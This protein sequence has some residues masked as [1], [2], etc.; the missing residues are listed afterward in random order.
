MAR[1]A[2]PVVGRNLRIV[3]SELGTGGVAARSRRAGIRPGTRRPEPAPACER[4]RPSRRDA[5]SLEPVERRRGSWNAGQYH[6]PLSPRRVRPASRLCPVAHG[7]DVHGAGSDVQPSS[8]ANIPA[9]SK[10]IGCSGSTTS[11]PPARSSGRQRR[12]HVEQLEMLGVADPHDARRL[13]RDVQAA[14]D[15]HRQG[16]A[17]GVDRER[18]ACA[19]GSLGRDA[20][21]VRL[22][23]VDSLDARAQGDVGHADADRVALGLRRSGRA[24]RCAEWPAAVPVGPRRSSGRPRW[25]PCPGR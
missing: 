19:L 12:A 2:L 16:V 3:R 18:H 15:G 8:S 25:N 5:R 24:R 13:G 20:V 21:H 11:Q 14:R 9:S 10:W 1:R 7:C 4:S 17:I 6:G 22:V 23:P